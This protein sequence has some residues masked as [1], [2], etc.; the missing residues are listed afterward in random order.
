MYRVRL[1]PVEPGPPLSQGSNQAIDLHPGQ[2]SDPVILR[3]SIFSKVLFPAPLRPDQSDHFALTNFKPYISQSPD[4]LC[5]G[6][7]PL[8]GRL[9]RD[10]GWGKQAC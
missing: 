7:L 6:A 5:T 3:E 9:M 10:S 2:Q 4:P 8:G 1:T